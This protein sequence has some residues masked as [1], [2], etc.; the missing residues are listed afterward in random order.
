MRNLAS[1][2]E[3]RE[4]NIHPNADKMEIATVLGGWHV[5]VKKGE[6]KAG[7]K[8]VYIET[9]SMVPRRPSFEFL[10]KDAG[11]KERVKI[12]PVRLRGQ[13]SEGILFRPEALFDN[14]ADLNIGDDV[15][16]HLDIIKYEPPE[17]SGNTN[18]MGSYPS[19][20]C[21][22]SDETRVQSLQALVTKYQGIRF[23]A[24]VKLDGSSTTLACAGL[25]G[26]PSD[27]VLASRNQRLFTSDQFVQK[28]PDNPVPEPSH[29][30][31][32]L[33]NV[34]AFER[35]RHWCVRNNRPIALQGECLGPKVQGNKYRLSNY[36]IRF[37]TMVDI[38]TGTYI[39]YVDKK[40]ILEEM[41]LPMVPTFVE[42]MVLPSTSDELVEMATSSIYYD[43]PGRDI[44]PEFMDEGLVFVPMY[45]EYLELGD[46]GR[47][48][49]ANRVSFKAINPLFS[50]RYK[51]D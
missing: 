40:R 47:L 2:V 26:T 16:E 17:T 36:T 33:Y 4:V 46:I 14:V 25:S 28:F 11:T 51:N 18:S 29:F 24:T 41:G 35:L 20:I 43:A 12:K 44:Y 3:I 21:P 50:E 1:I 13:L 38:R 45:L 32:C 42:D 48:L 15:T 49:N 7:D 5:C 9:D 37:F 39:P 23:A 31:K 19:N 27:F 34:E 30:E 8:A 22:K 6:F 10:F